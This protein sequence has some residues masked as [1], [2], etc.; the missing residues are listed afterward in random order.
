MANLSGGSGN[1]SFQIKPQGYLTGTIEGGGGTNTLDYS[2]YGQAVGYH[3]STGAAYSVAGGALNIQALIGSPSGTTLYGP[4]TTSTWTMTGT[5]AGNLNGTFTFSGVTGLRGG[6]GTNT[7]I[8]SAGT[9]SWVLTSND[10][11]TL[12]GTLTFTNMANLTGGSGNNS[13]QIQPQGYLTGTIEGGGGTNTLD[14]SVYGQAIGYHLSTGAAYSVAGGAL[15][16]QTLIG[17]PSGTTLYGPNTTSTWTMTGTGAGNLNGTFTFS[18]VTGLRGG[19]GT[20]TLIGSAGTNSWV[21]TSNDAG[22]LNGTLTFTNMANLTGG[23]GNNSFQIQPNGYL[24]G[25]IEGGGGTNTL[26]YSVYGQ[27][28]GYH[29]S[30]GAAYSVAG[31]ASNIQGLIGSPSGTTLY[32]PNTSS[33]WTMTGTGAGNLNGTFTFSGVTGLRGGTGTNTLIGSASTNSWVLTSN[34]AGTLGT[35]TFTNMA[36]LRA[37]R[38]ITPSRS[39]PMATSPARSRAAA[40]STR[41]TTRSTARPSGTT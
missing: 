15:N 24:T 22:T 14:Y 39:S 35:L 16:I 38:A 10:A 40:A 20:N 28:I 6:T 13:F 33:T 32:G 8:G 41:S 1:N 17:S 29:L 19:T 23:S 2:V 3:L 37:D 21:L 30:T 5:G 9:N 26:D 31:G 11:G 4:N 7:L 18:G 12:N 36:N 25:T 34:D 27:A